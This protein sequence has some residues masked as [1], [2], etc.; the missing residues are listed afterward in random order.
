MNRKEAAIAITN[1]FINNFRS[2]IPVSF[3]NQSTFRFCTDP[4]TNTTKPSDTPWVTF[5]V[6]DNLT[7]RSTLGI[8]GHRRFRRAGF[9]SSRVFVPENAGT[10][11]GRDICEEIIGIFEGERIATDIVFTYGDYRKAGTN[12]NGWFQF[13]IVIYFTFDEPK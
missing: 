5:S 2:D 7:V 11:L 3:D 6:R 8:K 10:S 13:N 9:I 1:E 12:E 4:L